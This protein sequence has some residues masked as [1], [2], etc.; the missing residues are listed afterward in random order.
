MVNFQTK[1]INTA[2]YE[3]SDCYSEYISIWFGYEMQ[4]LLGE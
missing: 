4:L 2:R 1:L 3:L